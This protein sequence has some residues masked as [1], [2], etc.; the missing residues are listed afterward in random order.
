MG[1]YNNHPTLPGPR[2]WAIAPMCLAPALYL[3]SDEL[4]K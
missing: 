2:L 4:K 1:P 3:R